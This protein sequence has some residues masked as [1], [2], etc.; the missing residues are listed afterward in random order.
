MDALGTIL[1]TL[2][3]LWLSGTCRLGRACVF[4][5]AT[6]WLVA[7]WPAGRLAA[8]EAAKAH[9]LEASRELIHITLVGR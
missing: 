5:S 2:S 9:L 7:C 3:L 6:S 1:L 4:Q 8:L